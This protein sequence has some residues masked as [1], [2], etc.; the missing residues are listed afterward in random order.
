[1]MLRVGFLLPSRDAVVAGDSCLGRLVDLAVRAEE[2]GFDSVWAGDSPV[3]RP[4][5]D[6]MVLLAAV[7][8]RTRRVQLGTAVLLPAL[9]SAI[10]LAHQLA[11]L[12]AVAGGRLVL[13]VGSG[14]P[15]P[16]TRAQFAAAGVPYE[17]R[18]ARMEDTIRAMRSLW[19]ADDETVSF[20]GPYVRFADAAVRPGPTSTGGPPI[21]LAG[22][23]DRAERRVGRLGD[24]WIPY[25][26]DPSEYAAG[27]RRVREAA[28]EAGRA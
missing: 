10:L 11:S 8:A 15:Y 20:D 21:W 23:G 5:A 9:R 3:V 22:A 4:R 24:G 14:F 28:A 16:P 7:A 26:P 27:L 18:L 17:G 6:A 1:M 13:G 25:P 2:L 19:A 12:D